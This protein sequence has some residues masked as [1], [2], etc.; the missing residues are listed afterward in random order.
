M[1]AAQSPRHMLKIGEVEARTGF[2][3]SYI[4]AKAAAGTFPAP[5][6][7]GGKSSR[8]DSQAVDAWIAAQFGR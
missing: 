4:Y 1:N 2:K 5:A 6:K 3:K 7:I 8:W